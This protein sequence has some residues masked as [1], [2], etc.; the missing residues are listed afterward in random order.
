MTPVLPWVPPWHFCSIFL[1]KQELFTPHT[2]SL[3]KRGEEM[4]VVKGRWAAGERLSTASLQAQFGAAGALD[5]QYPTPR[6]GQRCWSRGCSEL[7]CVLAPIPQ[8]SLCPG[9][10]GVMVKNMWF[11]YSSLQRCLSGAGSS[12]VFQDVAASDG[13]QK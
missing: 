4:P 6:L 5:P 9:L 11:G 8:C 1:N 10:H 3:W 12:A 13:G 7:P 2:R